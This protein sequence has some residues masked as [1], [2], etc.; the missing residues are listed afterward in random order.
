MNKWK[1]K[2]YIRE[3]Y[4]RYR[5]AHKEELSIY[6]KYWV[7]NNRERV[8]ELNR[9]SYHKCKEEFNAIRRLRYLLNK[10]IG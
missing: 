2:Q 10:I 8:N 6:A 5:I 1:D 7:N 9:N 3:Y 4:Q